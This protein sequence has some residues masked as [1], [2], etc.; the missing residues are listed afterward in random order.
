MRLLCVL[1]GGADHPSSR[2]RVLQHIELLRGR[3]VEPDVFVAKGTRAVDLV[4]LAGRARRAD[5]VLVQKKLFARWKLPLL[6]GPAPVLFDLDDAVF[7]VSPDERER[8]G[9]ERATRRAESRRLRLASVLRRSRGVLAG[10]RFLAEYA[11][12]FAADVTV[13]PTGVDLAPFPDDAIRRARRTRRERAAGM[14]I[15]WIGS[16]PS[17]RYL[18]ELAEPLRLVSRSHPAMRFVQVCNAFADLP[19]VPTETI[20]WS[21][22]GEAGAL[23]DCDIG[24]MPLDESP[25][26]QGKCGF[27]ILMYYAAGLPVVCSP[28][29][30]NRDLVVHGETGLFARTEE[31]WASAL[32]RLLADPDLCTAMGDRGRTLLRER[33]E[34]TVIGGRLADRVAALAGARSSAPGGGAAS[35]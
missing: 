24:V 12:R 8:F 27:K 6:L 26:S 35:R 33:Y 22:E 30:A 31:E 1:N 13:L 23:L 32:G 28:V 18:G 19:G 25:F 29:G 14:R 34:A 2:L 16:R 20:A 11:Q 17:L 4:D 21:R 7:A 3:G 10:N 9:E 15:V 5:L